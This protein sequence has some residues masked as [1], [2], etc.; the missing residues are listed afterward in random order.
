VKTIYHDIV[1]DMADVMDL[2]RNTIM[3]GRKND[4]KGKIITIWL[5]VSNFIYNFQ[6]YKWI[7]F[8]KILT[9]KINITNLLPLKS[10]IL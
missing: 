10:K 9:Q 7:Q 5:T 3:L 8:R 6:T 1:T 4:N 2:R